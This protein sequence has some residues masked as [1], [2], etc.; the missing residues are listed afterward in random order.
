MIDD[1]SSTTAVLNAALA[2]ENRPIFGRRQINHSPPHPVTQ[3]VA[4]NG[5]I[6]LVLQVKFG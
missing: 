3:L 5:K 2:S 4:A 6:V 1:P